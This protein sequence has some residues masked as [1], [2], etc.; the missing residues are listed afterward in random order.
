MLATASSAP[1]GLNATDD[2]S[3]PVA[4]GE[5]GTGDSAPAE[6]TENTATWLPW[7]FAVA[8]NPPDGL[9]ATATGVVPVENG[10]PG[11]WVNTAGDAFA[12]AGPTVS[13]PPQTSARMTPNTRS[14]LPPAAGTGPAYTQ[15]TQS[16]QEPR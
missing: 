7:E 6:E 1:E 2:G 8:S 15:A 4:N 16:G 3:L 12:N 11:T 5:P 13:I 10:E 14:L 9:N